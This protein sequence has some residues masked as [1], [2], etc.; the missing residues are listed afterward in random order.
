MQPES[1]AALSRLPK[2]E[3]L[4]FLHSVADELCGRD[5]PWWQ[6]GATQNIHEWQDTF[7]L[8]R[9]ALAQAA[10]G[11]ES[12]SGPRELTECVAGRRAELKA[13]L[14][15][16]THNI[17]DVRLGDFNW[18]LKLALSSDRL[19]CLQTPLL[20]LGL[21]VEGPGV[22]GYRDQVSLEMGRA[23]LQS[24]VSTLEQAS[25]VVQQTK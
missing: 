7:R 11:V 15:D 3:R 6:I 21:N 20:S 9:D 10:Q 23:E 4:Q 5:G 8:S 14:L 18:V 2:E 22:D 16:A 25:K 1:R 19:A 13:G 17:S 24:L 12:T